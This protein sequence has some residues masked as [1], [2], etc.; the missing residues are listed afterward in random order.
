MALG[1]NLGRYEVIRLADLADLTDDD[2]LEVKA[3]AKPGG[4]RRAAA[5][6]RWF[7]RGGDG[8][9]T[10]G[11][12]GDMTAC[13][14][15]AA[16]HMSSERAW[17]FC[18]C[19]HRDATGRAGTA[20]PTTEQRGATTNASGGA[21][22][23]LARCSNNV[24]RAAWVY[25]S[26]PPTGSMIHGEQFRRRRCRTEVGLPELRHVKATGWWR[27][28]LPGSVNSKIREGWRRRRRRRRGVRRVGGRAAMRGIAL[29]RSPQWCRSIHAS[30][31][32]R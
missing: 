6:I 21:N 10:W 11:S 23:P 26:M 32:S 16:Q 19:R 3:N 20:P 24:V 7:N 29:T 22:I 27:M 14:A 12:E 4:R 9:W 25:A 8:R 13:H 2:E 1:D 28:P 5:L 17:A 15:V 30:F 18:G 31:P